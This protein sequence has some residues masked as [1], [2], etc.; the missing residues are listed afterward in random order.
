[1]KVGAKSEGPAEWRSVCVAIAWTEASVFFT[2][3]LS[4]PI[5]S[6]CVA[7]ARLRS[8]TSRICT[9]TETSRSPS[10]SAEQ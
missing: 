5:S 7:S 10:N 2:R 4:S 6:R 8:V 3:W 1:M 9:L